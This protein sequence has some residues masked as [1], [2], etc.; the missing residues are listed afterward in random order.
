MEFLAG[1]AAKIVTGLVNNLITFFQQEKLKAEAE[2]AKALE[3][4]IEGRKTKEAAQKALR[5][6]AAK[7]VE[8]SYEA[9]E[10]MRTSGTPA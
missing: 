3:A 8:F 2:K 4:Y 6:E 5:E 9:W 7:K 1:L 10:A